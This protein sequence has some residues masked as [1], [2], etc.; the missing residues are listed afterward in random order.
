MHI[1]HSIH[2]SFNDHIN[3]SFKFLANRSLNGHFAFC[4]NSRK[5]V[6]L[7]LPS[8]IIPLVFGA[9]SSVGRAPALQAGGRRFKPVIA[10]HALSE[11]EVLPN[12]GA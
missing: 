2:L 8:V 3:V 1:K 6:D 11:I 4:A 7:S 12:A 9:I 5:A 10:H